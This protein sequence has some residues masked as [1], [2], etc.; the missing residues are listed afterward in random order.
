MKQILLIGLG[1][2]LGSILRYLTSLLTAKFWVSG[3]PLGTFLANI[4]GCFIIGLLLGK[5]GFNLQDKESLKFLFVTG[6]CGGYTTF[7]AFAFESM[8]LF[9]SQMYWLGIVY[10]VLSV[11]LGLLAVA[12]AMNI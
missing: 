8:Q 10:V 3:F 1:G 12:L 2:G 5:L 6:F 9:Q 11:L 4:I 7:S